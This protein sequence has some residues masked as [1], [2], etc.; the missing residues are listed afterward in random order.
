[1]SPLGQS[2][3]TLNMPDLLEELTRETIE[4]LLKEMP[5]EKRLEGL[6]LEER[7]KGVSPEML[8]ALAD[9]LSREAEEKP[10]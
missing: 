10:Q 2:P 6:S 1:V 5:V 4:Q 3:E 8:R 7:V 9:R